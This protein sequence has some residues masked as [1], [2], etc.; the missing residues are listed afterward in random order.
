MPQLQAWESEQK[1]SF[2][3]IEDITR[4]DSEQKR[5]VISDN[6]DFNQHCNNV[7]YVRFANIAVPDD[8]RKDKD[9]VQVR[10]QYKVPAIQGDKLTVQTQVE[11]RET[12][13]KIVSSQNRSIEYA[14]IQMKWRER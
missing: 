11:E 10:I 5:E 4:T 14:R 9:L 8:F 1:S 2:E 13:H 6:I 3:A 7:N 12:R